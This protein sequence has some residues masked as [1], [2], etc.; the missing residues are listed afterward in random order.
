MIVRLSVQREVTERTMR[1]GT[2]AE[3]MLRPDRLDG[4][5]PSKHVVSMVVLCSDRYRY[6]KYDRDDNALC[7]GEY[8]K[9]YNY[10]RFALAAISLSF[11]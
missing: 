2:F 4:R 10:N 1:D 7:T 8:S 3:N 11:P 9:S 6:L 5:V